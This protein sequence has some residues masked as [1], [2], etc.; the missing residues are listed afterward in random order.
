MKA[1]INKITEGAKKRDTIGRN[2]CLALNV[3]EDTC[4]KELVNLLLHAQLT[5]SSD[6]LEKITNVIIFNDDR[7][8][9]LKFRMMDIANIH[10]QAFATIKERNDIEVVNKQA[11]EKNEEG[12]DE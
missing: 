5:V 8:Y 2:I 11:L 12:D 7:A 10:P 9:L 6:N 1:A 3:K 4:A